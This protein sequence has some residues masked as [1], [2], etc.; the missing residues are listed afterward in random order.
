MDALPCFGAADAE[1]EE[2]PPVHDPYEDDDSGMGSDDEAVTVQELPGG[3]LT[4]PI[5][6]EVLRDARDPL[7]EVGGAE[8]LAD[9][10]S[11]AAEFLLQLS[12]AERDAILSVLAEGRPSADHKEAVH[13]VQNLIVHIPDQAAAHAELKRSCL[14][15]VWV[16]QPLSGKVSQFLEK[17][18]RHRTAKVRIIGPWEE[19][20]TRGTE[21]D[22]ARR[23]FYNNETQKTQW[24]PP[25]EFQGMDVIGEEEEDDE[26]A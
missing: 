1:G 8:S 4:R 22:G 2:A 11:S 3:G 24:D 21:N 13:F 10:V 12:A 6:G 18:R 15:G 26:D 5:A 7:I 19:H 23:Y 20:Y 16:S 14:S 17:R 9:E 25:P